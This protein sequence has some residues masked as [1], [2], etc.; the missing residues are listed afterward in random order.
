MLFVGNLRKEALTV[1]QKLPLRYTTGYTFRLCTTTTPPIDYTIPA[2]TPGSGAGKG[3]GP[4]GSVREAGGGLGKLGAALEEGYFHQQ[5][6]EQLKQIKQ[7]LERGEQ[8]GYADK[9]PQ[10]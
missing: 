10:K 1:L 9:P 7:K 4:G 2:G 5:Q 3:G 8:I 6:K